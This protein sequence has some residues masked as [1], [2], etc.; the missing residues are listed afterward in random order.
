MRVRRVGRRKEQERGGRAPRV[1]GVNI[2]VN[3]NVNVN[4]VT[5]RHSFRP[6]K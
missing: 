6:S 5:A 4:I 3:V 1:V 2:N